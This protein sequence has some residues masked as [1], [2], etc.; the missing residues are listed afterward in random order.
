MLRAPVGE[1]EFGREPGHVVEES[2][3][4]SGTDRAILAVSLAQGVVAGA[5]TI[6]DPGPI[7]FAGPCELLLVNDV[8]P[9]AIGAF[10]KDFEQENVLRRFVFIT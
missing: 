7:L 2:T 3:I 5:D 10:R 4:E 9:Q 8:G 1:G 6:T